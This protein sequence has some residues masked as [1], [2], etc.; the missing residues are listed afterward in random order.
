M[1]VITIPKKTLR[2]ALLLAILIALGILAIDH[3]PVPSPQPVAPTRISEDDL[4]SAAAVTAL[5]AFYHLDSHAGQIAWLERL[6]AASTPAGC[7]LI[8]LGADRLWEQ[9]TATQSAV[10]ATAEVEEKLADTG[11][12][13][14]WRVRISLSAPLSVSGHTSEVAYVVVRKTET[15]WLFDRFLLEAEISAILAQKTVTPPKT[16]AGS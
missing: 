13:Q 3:L 10:T 7:Q 15:G 12:E 16:G 6:C 5:E 8:S 9:L 1:K 2:N 14:V 11:F 4:G